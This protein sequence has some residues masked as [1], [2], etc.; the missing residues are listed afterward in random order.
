MATL[1]S[2]YRFQEVGLTP[3]QLVLVGT[4]LEATVLLAELPTGVLADAVSRRRSLLVG[5]VLIGVGFVLEGLVPT[6]AAVLLAQAVWGLGAAFESGA[7]EAWL[8]DEIGERAAS[9]AFLR[10]AQVQQAAALVGIPVAALTG[11]VSLGLPLVVGGVGFLL[12]ALFLAL[13]MQETGFEPRQGVDRDPVRGCIVRDVRSLVGGSDDLGAGTPCPDRPTHMVRARR[14]RHRRTGHRLGRGGAAGP[15]SSG[16]RRPGPPPTRGGAASAHAASGRSGRRVRPGGSA[17]SGRLDVPPGSRVGPAERAAVPGVAEP[18]AGARDARHRVF[19]GGRRRRAG[20]GRGRSAAGTGRG[21]GGHA[22]RVR[23][24]GDA[25]GARRLASGPGVAARAECR[26]FR[27]IGARSI[28]SAATVRTA[29]W[30]RR[31][32]M[33][34]GRT[35]RAGSPSV[36]LRRPR[37]LALPHRSRRGVARDPRALRRDER[38][39]RIPPGRGDRRSDVVE[40]VDL[41]RQL[42]GQLPAARQAAGADHRTAFGR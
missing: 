2:V 18:R 12:L 13:S 11:R 17:R 28:R 36:A 35:L 30:A 42:V 15:G 7:V 38:W 9:R 22:G 3:L 32:T 8:S 20:S 5:T 31:A 25:A 24:R 29:S 26:T 1:A 41:L 19:G 21:R 34:H 33:S 4:V 27:R 37:R 39:I 6:L 40:N 23:G 14:G 16:S 10:A